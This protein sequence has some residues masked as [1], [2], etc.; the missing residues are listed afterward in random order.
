MEYE[1]SD[2]VNCE[3]LAV[4]LSRRTR[5]RDALLKAIKTAAWMYDEMALGPLEAAC[6]YGDNYEPPSDA[7]W[8]K[9]RQGLHDAI[10]LCEA[11]QHDPSGK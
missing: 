1:N 2:C 11:P 9:M 4:K 5:E 6:K 8:L 10:A 3:N 7:E